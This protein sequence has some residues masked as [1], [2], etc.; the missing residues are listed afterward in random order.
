MSPVGFTLSIDPKFNDFLSPNNYHPAPSHLHLSPEWGTNF[1]TGLP[2]AIL[3]A[4]IYFAPADKVIFSKTHHVTPL[5][6]VLQETFIIL[7]LKM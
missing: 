1:L 4:T 5:L 6:K 3:V 7:R 2:A